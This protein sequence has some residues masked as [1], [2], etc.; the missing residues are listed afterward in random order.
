MLFDKTDPDIALSRNNIAGVLNA[1]GKHNKA[2]KFLAGNGRTF[3]IRELSKKLAI[4]PSEYRN[5]RRLIKEAI[6]EGKLSRGKGGKLSLPRKEDFLTGKL[7][8]S[9]AGYGF[10]ITE[11][12]QGDI[13][14]A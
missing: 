3:K 7:F 10:V 6:S 9:R 4:K 13:F 12:E 2:L 14:A 5:F 11:R 8:V 1:Y